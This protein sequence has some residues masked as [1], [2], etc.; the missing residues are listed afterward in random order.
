[1]AEFDDLGTVEQ[2][3]D[4]GALAQTGE[5]LT[6]QAEPPP[7][8]T[9]SLFGEPPPDP[10]DPNYKYWQGAYTKT[11]QHDRQRDSQRYGKLESEHQQFG[12]VLRNFYTSDEYALQVLRQRFPQLA[13]RLSL[14][15]TLSPGTQNGAPSTEGVLT[16]HL[17]AGL[18]PDLQFLAPR[19]GPA[20]EA[21]MQAY[22]GQ[23]V[24]P[25]QQQTEQQ[26]VATRRAQEDELLAALDSQHPGWEARYGPQMKALDDFLNSDA[27]THPTFGDKYSLYLRLLNPDL[28]RVDAARSMSAASRARLV[29]GRAGRTSSPATEQQ[30]LS[31]KNSAEAFRLAAQAAMQELRRGA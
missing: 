19:L 18:D 30:V 14:D 21:A 5:E 8:E 9:D 3:L 2:P 1:M 22:V 29:T 10:N 26:Q 24:R 31:A 28:A 13:S 16:Q 11:R 15:G 12:E 6:G 17:L 7:E 27:L 25:L 4:A 23:A 20:I